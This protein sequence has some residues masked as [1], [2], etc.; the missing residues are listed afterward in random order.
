[1]YVSSTK[2]PHQQADIRYSPSSLVLWHVRWN[3]NPAR[4]LAD[5]LGGL[6]E[7][8]V[9]PH[10]RM[11]IGAASA[12]ADADIDNVGKAADVEDETNWNMG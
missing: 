6:E 11:T 8:W 2:T 9:Q 10:S 4:K 1:M 3:K 12:D 5:K 7:L